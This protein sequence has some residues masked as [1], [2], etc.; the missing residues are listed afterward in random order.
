MAI[1]YGEKRTGLAVTDPLRII[2][3]PLTTVNTTTLLSFITDYVKREPVDIFVI[4]KPLHMNNTPSQSMPLVEAFASALHSEF[5][6]IPIE[7]VD[8]RFTSKI[9]SRAIID[10]GVSKKRR[11]D[12]ALIDST[13]AT[14][15]LQTYLDTQKNTR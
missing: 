14:I 2:A 12:K 13:A 7:L 11:K 5:D 4:G 10:S 6:D 3:T 9:A 8:E 15:I 1:D